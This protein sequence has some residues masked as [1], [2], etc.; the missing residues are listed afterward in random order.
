[1]PTADR[2]RALLAWYR[3]ARRDL[4]WRRTRDPYAIWISEVMLQQTR[5]DTAIGYY[6]RFLRRFPTIASLARADIASVL[7]IWAGLGYYRRARHLHAAAKAVLDKHGGEVPSDL[8]SLRALPGVGAYTAGAVASIAFDVAAP[9]VDG[10]VVRVLARWHGV[11]EDPHAGAGRRR[12]EELARDAV[13]SSGSPGDWNQALMELGATVCVP[14]QPK[15]L[16]CP[17][18]FACEA[19][20]RGLVARIPR[21]K[22]R[23]KSI[24]VDHAAAVIEREE[25]YFFVRRPEGVR[26]A[27]LYEFPTV[28]LTDGSEP[29][30]ALAGFVRESTGLPVEFGEPIAELKHTITNQ[31]I[32]VRAFAATTARPETGR[33]QWL[34]PAAARRKG[35]TAAARKILERI[36]APSQERP[37]PA[38]SRA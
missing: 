20:L 5:V 33:G 36:A 19:R 28:E 31:R 4:P 11:E 29:K 2:T 12:L 15:C 25:T 21:P 26:L 30:H 7:S 6:E 9:A 16:L 22:P 34:T 10:N 13:S 32:R 24:A 37:G 18:A 23:A 27:G 38:P 3:D 1:V 8:T 35:L 17:V 14:S